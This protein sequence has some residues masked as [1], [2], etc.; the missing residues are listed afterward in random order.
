MEGKGPGAQAFIDWFFR[1]LLLAFHKMKM[2]G[3]KQQ[4]HFCILKAGYKLDIMDFNV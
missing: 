4:V 2:H 3:P 1:H